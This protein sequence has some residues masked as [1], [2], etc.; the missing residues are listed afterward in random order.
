VLRHASGAE[1]PFFVMEWVEGTPLYVWADQ[2]SPCSQ[3]VFLLL[4][5]LARA[6][7]TTHAAHA[8]HRDVKGDN[9]RVR[10]SDGRA[11]L[12]DFGSGH[13]RGASRLTWKSLPPVTPE[14]L[15]AQAWLFNLRLAHAPDSYYPPTAADDLHALGVTAY[16]LVMGEY[17]PAMDARQ[18]E[19]GSWQV[20]SPDPRPQLENNPRVEPRLR[21]W[22]L[23]LLSDAPEARGTAAQLAEA[24]EAE[25]E[26]P[27][28]PRARGKAWRPWLAL[29]AAG[30]S[31]VLLWPLKPLPGHVSAST[32]QAEDSQASEADPT[33]VGDTSSTEPLASIHPPSEQ[34]PIAQEPL[35]QPR[36]WQARPDEKGR[37]LGPRQVPINGGCWVEQLP[38]SAEECVEGG[39]VPFKGKCY[40]PAPAPPKK[41][42]PTSDP[43]EAR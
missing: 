41:S 19:H 32:R 18:D 3:Q 37:C 12:L 4:A 34:A 24:L 31:A 23:R 35:P 8:V 10:L 40:L 21:E 7:A 42:V 29:A 26:L 39:Y 17:P 9:I 43:G 2:H 30:A 11:V 36:P 28:R 22:I 13:F 1:Q 15:S 14:Y 16:R 33:A 38:M 20:T 6:L 27:K 5:Q 25:A